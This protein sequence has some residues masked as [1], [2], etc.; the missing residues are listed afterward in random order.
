MDIL[1]VNRFIM[2]K[3]NLPGKLSVSDDKFKETLEAA[4][5]AEQAQVNG[6]Q[7]STTAGAVKFPEDK[8]VTI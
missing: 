5:Q 1:E 4:A 8:G 7:P 6:A 2:E 3:L